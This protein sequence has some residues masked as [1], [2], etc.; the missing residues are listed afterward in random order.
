MPPEIEKMKALRVF[1]I[2]Y[3][4][5]VDLPL[6]LGGISALRMLKVAGNPLNPKLKRILEHGE[7]ALS[8]PMSVVKN[9]ND[10]DTFLTKKVTE[11]L[12]HE[13]VAGEES[14][15]IWKSLIHTHTFDF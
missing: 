3:N 11:F 15:Y 7:K 2:Q 4:N 10:R 9:D 8:P 6:C 12:R 5:I 13:A 1:S 14:R